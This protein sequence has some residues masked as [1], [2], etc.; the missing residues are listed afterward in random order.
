M[1]AGHKVGQRYAISEKQGTIGR[2]PSNAIQVI[3]AEVSRVHCRYQIDGN[4]LEVADLQSA[5]GTFVNGKTVERYKLDD[6]D[7]IKLGSTV[8][9]VKIDTTV[10]ETISD[11]E[12][13]IHGKCP[14]TELPSSLSYFPRGKNF[15]NDRHAKQTCADAVD[16]PVRVPQVLNDMSFIY[17]A[18]LVTSSKADRQEMLNE[19]VDLIFN[20]VTADRCGV[21]LR[22]VS[23]DKL[24]TQVMRSRPPESSQSNLVIS[25][26]IVDYVCEHRI[27]ILT[28]N[29]LG[30]QRF[31][32]K[33]SIKQIGVREAICVPING[34]DEL[35]GV[36]YLD[37]LD[38]DGKPETD[39]FNRNNLK[40]MIAIGLQIGFAIENEQYF[41]KRL[42]QQRLVTI[43]RTTS[44]LSHHMK[45]VLQ[46]VNGGAHLVETGLQANDLETIKAGW[47]IVNRNQ[48]E[49]SKM[50]NDML[51]FGKPYDPHFAQADLNEVIK[52]VFNEIEPSLVRRNI[53]YDWSPT[54]EPVLL[55]L[56]PRGIHWALFNLINSC[57]AACHGL[58]HGNIKVTVALSGDGNVL[59]AIADNGQSVQEN[60]VEDVFSPAP[61][62]PDHSMN[63]VELAVSRKIIQ[64]HS[65]EV[66]LKSS[67]LGGNLF[68]IK[69]P[70][71]QPS[72]NRTG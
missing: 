29:A 45:N 35:L 57:A 42:E 43:G 39:R 46:G 25:K 59:I 7:R 65:G 44:S 58:T 71:K 66:K 13:P 17:D 19:I 10:D 24:T 56:D 70:L 6:G 49:I 51:M 31:P 72:S 18:S 63:P 14:T 5:N 22:D 32:S 67:E 41:M 33:G 11:T 28:S 16:D 23:T 47:A 52:Q 40:L 55:K 37:A 4:H 12:F 54:P 64:G 8:F 3:D 1:I 21:L 60:S 62:D 38:P 53:Q 27:G 69:L 48:S 15:F 68:Q 50:V 9:E 2:G 36:I 61:S 34:R 26:S 30:D 20:W